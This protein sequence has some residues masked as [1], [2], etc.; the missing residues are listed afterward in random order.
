MIGF[1]EMCNLEK[2]MGIGSGL[3]VEGV[4]LGI[5]KKGR[6]FKVCWVFFCNGEDNLEFGGWCLNWEYI[7]CYNGDIYCM[8]IFF[9]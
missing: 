1:C 9:F 8:C 7:K 5:V 3:I 2:F 4:W 6:L